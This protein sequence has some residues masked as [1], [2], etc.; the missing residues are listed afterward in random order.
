ML[1]VTVN[2]VDFS[3]Y[4]V[5]TTQVVFDDKLNLSKILNFSVY[6]ANSSFPIVIANQRVRLFNDSRVIFTGYVT[7]TPAKA[8]IISGFAGYNV[9][10]KSD[11]SI[12]DTDPI[13]PSIT[14]VGLSAGVILQN[15]VTILGGTNIDFSQV[16][17]GPIVPQ[18]IAQEGWTFTQAAQALAQ[19]IGWRWYILDSVLFFVS[20]NDK[21]YGYDISTN[22]ASF[23]AGNLNVINSNV[24][25]VN[26]ISAQGALEPTSYVNENFVGDGNTA[27][28]N[29]FKQPLGV[30]SSSVLFS[31]SF[32]STV[33]NTDAWTSKDP[34]NAISYQR[35]SVTVAGGTSKVGDTVIYVNDPFEIGGEYTF[36]LGTFTFN[37]LSNGILGGIYSD[38]TFANS[39][40]FTGIWATGNTIRTGLQALINGQPQTTTLV[41]QPNHAYQLLAHVSVDSIY[42]FRDIFRSITGQFGGD[43]V[44]SDGYVTIEILDYNLSN[45]TALPTSTILFDARVANIPAF[46]YVGLFNCLSLFAVVT[47]G[48]KVT[49]LDPIRVRDASGRIS[50]WSANQFGNTWQISLSQTPSFNDPVFI[51]YRSVG[52]VQSHIT[53]NANIVSTSLKSATLNL[54]PNVRSSADC[55]NLLQAYLSDHSSTLFE[56]SYVLNSTA[57]N[58]IPTSGRN[59]NVNVPSLGAGVFVSVVR[60]AVVSFTD[61]TNEIANISTT[62]GFAPLMTVYS[63]SNI[64][65]TTPSN[66]ISSLPLFLD[67]DT[68]FQTPTITGAA[69]NA[70]GGKTP[71]SKFQVRTDDI[72]WGTSSGGDFVSDFTTQTFSLTRTSRANVFFVREVNGSKFSR[73][74]TILLATG[75]PILTVLPLTTSSITVGLNVTYNINLGSLADMDSVLILGTDGTTQVFAQKVDPVA[76]ALQTSPQITFTSTNIDYLGVVNQRNYTNYQ[77]YTLNFRGERSTVRLVSGSLPLPAAPN[78]LVGIIDGEAVTFTLSTEARTDFVQEIL[79]VASD[80]GFS[81]IVAIDSEDAQFGTSSIDVPAIGTYFVRARK[82]DA[83]GF[84]PNSPLSENLFIFSSQ[85]DNAIWTQTLTG[86]AASATI[87]PNATVDPTGNLTADKIVFPSTTSAQTTRISQAVTIP[88]PSVGSFYTMSIWLRA[89]I[90]QTVFI[91]LKKTNSGGTTTGPSTT[92]NVTTQWQQFTATGDASSDGTTILVGV[93]SQL[94]SSPGATVYVWEAQIEPGIFATQSLQTISTNFSS[95]TPQTFVVTT[96]SSVDKNTPNPPTTILAPTQAI[97]KSADGTLVENVTL[98][99]AAPVTI[100]PA[101]TGYLIRYKVSTATVYTYNRVGNVT[102]ATIH[103]LLLNTTYNFSVAS[104]GEVSQQSSFPTDINVTTN[105]NAIAPSTVTGLTAIGS[106][107]KVSLKWTSVTDS[108]LA[109][110]QVEWAPDVSGSPGTFQ[111]ITKANASHY[112]DS[113]DSTRGQL[114]VSTPYW[115]RVSAFNTT[116]VQGTLSSNVTATTT[117]VGLDNDVSD[118]GTFRRLANVN[119]DNTLH[120]STSLNPQGS[121]LP[122]QVVLL[123]F[124]MPSATIMIATWLQQSLLRPDSSSTIVVPSNGVGSVLLNGDGESGTLGAQALDWTVLAGFSGI[125]LLEVNDFVNSGTKS[126]KIINPSATNSPNQQVVTVTGGV[127]WVLEG[128]VKTTAISGGSPEGALL[129][130]GIISGSAVT[131]F[132]VITKFGAYDAG[133]TTVPTVGLPADSVARGF[134]FLQSYFI[135]NATGTV[136]LLC[137]LFSGNAASAWFDDVKVYPFGGAV[138]T[139]LTASTGY[140]LYP[141]LDIPTSTIKFSNGSPPGTSPSDVFS[142]QCSLDGRQSFPVTKVTT[143]TSGGT[144]GGTGGGSGTCPESNELVWLRRYSNDGELLFDGQIKVGL[145]KS[146]YESD[147]GTKKTGDFL[148]GFSFTRNQD[149]YRAVQQVQHAYCAGWMIVDGHRVTACESIYHQKEWK[150]AWRSQGAIQDNAIGTKVLIQVEA[151]WDDEHNYYIGDLLI[152]NGFILPC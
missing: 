151:D 122:N 130:L 124:T 78:I 9:V 42:R 88:T 95:P 23:V 119:I 77:F 75:Y 33:L 61:L 21:P 6:P 41:T 58:E 123:S 135:P 50:N 111:V 115:Y 99:W 134:T 91:F 150:P 60:E 72:N 84:G 7:A 35:K 116:A 129:N 71:V 26:D 8:N 114:A 146:G 149:V 94:T 69:I 74:S 76:L 39:S 120:V 81:T 147:D 141:Y 2:G 80:S 20:Q 104:M 100:P 15:L 79:E 145:V 121:V 27:V 132:T 1:H 24:Q 3:N 63:T 127:V 34:S 10:A 16:P 25:I 68:G 57:L 14:Y 93:L 133:L 143:P 102:T 92:C 109:F 73:F 37:N 51:H 17:Q 140:F 139:G 46:G 87:T 82:S 137:Q 108:D 62:F 22:D 45:P 105:N 48:P 112:D 110:Y 18:F 64:A 11:E 40:C 83:I 47:N 97:V 101:V 125:G 131:S 107:R 113:G 19:K 30:G 4:I 38:T 138:Y 28:F 36:D 13:S 98:T 31:D 43:I 96:V 136:S 103:G 118:G 29:L 59:L 56:G 66:D 32:S 65:G 85:F 90:A 67:D 53:N 55:E 117:T 52:N 44:K 144:G 86:G 12:F 148:K 54:P 70:D 5:P 128:W 126:M 49:Q 89:D 152:H 142:L 106:F